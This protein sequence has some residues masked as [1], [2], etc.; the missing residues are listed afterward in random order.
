[1]AQI[2]VVYDGYGSKV[3]TLIS[4]SLYISDNDNECIFILLALS[5]QIFP[6]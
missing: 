4:L 2:N 1:M 6:L 5:M 3:N